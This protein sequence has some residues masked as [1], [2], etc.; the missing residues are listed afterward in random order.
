MKEC[1]LE[2]KLRIAPTS[3]PKEMNKE[4]SLYGKSI[5]MTKVRSKSVEEYLQSVGA[6]LADS[7]NKN[8]FLLIVKN[9]KD[10][11]NKTEQAEKHNV[12]IMALEDFINDFMPSV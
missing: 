1:E 5:V 4:H 9:K 11:S 6:T 7:V 3:I 8:T 10:K 2:S 12:R